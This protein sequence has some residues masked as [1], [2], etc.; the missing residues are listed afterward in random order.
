[1]ALLDDDRLP[2]IR[3]AR[4]GSA[5][6]NEPGRELLGRMRCLRYGLL[7][8]DERPVRLNPA[9]KV[10]ETA[11]LRDAVVDLVAVGDERGAGADAGIQ[12]LDVHGAGPRLL[13]HL[14]RGLVAVDQV[15]VKQV[16]AQQVD[17]RLHSLADAPEPF[18]M[19]EIDQLILR[20]LRSTLN[21]ESA[22]IAERWTG[23]YPSSKTTPCVIDAPDDATR[24]VL[25][26]SGSG[27]STGFGIAHDVFN[28]W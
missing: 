25:V 16:V 24:L 5:F 15:R 19:E 28:A 3:H 20:H 7:G 13:E 23:V 2:A 22:Q 4:V 21:L 18:A 6:I 1:M 11:G 26:T 27:A 17:D 12:F 10:R 14:D 8:L 9:S